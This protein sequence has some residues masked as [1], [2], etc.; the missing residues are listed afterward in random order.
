M[1]AVIIGAGVNGLTA[2]ARLAKAGWRVDVFERADR[3]GGAARTDVIDGRLIDRGAACHPFG[4]ASPAFAQL[5]L[6]VE[7]LR[8]PIEMAHPLDDGA[9]FLHRSLA[10]TA[11]ELGPDA[12]VWRGIHAP[13]VDH[14][15]AH[16]AN[17]LAPPNRW[18]AH[19]LRLAQ[20][21]ARGAWPAAAVPLR[22]ERARALFAGS[23][24]HAILPPTRAGT[25]AFGV[26]FGALGMTRG[27]PVAK[28]GS[29]VVARGLAE[30]VEKHGGR[31]HC[32]RDVPHNAPKRRR[33]P[34]VHKVDFLLN[35]PVPWRDPR[36]G[37]AA[38]V[39]LGGTLREIDH[40][41][42]AIRR[43]RLPE[44]PFVMAAQQFV[45]DPQRGLSLWTY[46]HVPAGYRER[47]PGEVRELITR[48]VERF[49][50]GFRDVVE[51]VVEASPADLERWD[52]CLVGGDIANGAHPLIRLPHR[53]GA[54]EYLASSA[55]APGA[56]VHGM[57]GWWAAEAALRDFDPGALSG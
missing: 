22:T 21:G 13:V 18:P 32:N 7:W 57:P 11:A 10:Q 16:L 2:A 53:L 44:R 51:R 54:G 31:I 8:A 42:R 20:F 39:H 19:P 50:P 38:T 35:E 26:L 30:L 37:Q 48:Q 3:V 9:A 29:E 40:A 5:G 52:P 25:A 55:T 46:A 1:E 24:A 43:G 36:V 45:A 23:A 15:D 4:A 49:A 47:Y 12:R 6:D 27:W 56:G 33:G 14:I 41:E 17:A 28:G 34:G